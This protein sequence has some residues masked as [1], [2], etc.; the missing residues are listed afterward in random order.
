MK[1]SVDPSNIERPEPP[2]THVWW[3]AGEYERLP[4]RDD[5]EF[6]LRPA[7]GQRWPDDFNVYPLRYDG[8]ESM[9]AQL[10]PHDQFFRLGWQ[11]DWYSMDRLRALQSFVELYGLL[12]GIIN[13]QNALTPLSFMPWPDPFESPDGGSFEVFVPKTIKPNQTIDDGIEVTKVT[14]NNLP[15]HPRQ[16]ADF[17]YA[18]E[19]VSTH[20]RDIPFVQEVYGEYLGYD[21]HAHMRSIR[22]KF[23]GFYRYFHDGIDPDFVDERNPVDP[24]TD[25][26]IEAVV[27]RD[28]E[29]GEQRYKFTSLLNAMHFYA[30]EDL[31]QNKIG[32]CIECGAFYRTPDQ[33][34]RRFC[35]DGTDEDGKRRCRARAHERKFRQKQNWADYLEQHAPD[36]R[37]EW[38]RTDSG[39]LIHPHDIAQDETLQFEDRERGLLKDW[40]EQTLAHSSRDRPDPWLQFLPPGEASTF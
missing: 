26:S 17:E 20:D 38:P 3:V 31:S 15:S 19:V 32:W 29:S 22:S 18:D 14:V 9:D 30:Q 23:Y 28:P 12:G 11:S 2:R 35:P 33:H 21:G 36:V 24:E 4:I 8:F 25:R 5:G 7:A 10:F 34:E 13:T 16:S 40:I 27:E 37:S 1:R 39:H 6:V